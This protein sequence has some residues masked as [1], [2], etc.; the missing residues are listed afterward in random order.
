[1]LRDNRLKATAAEGDP[2]NDPAN[3]GRVYEQT[4]PP[5]TVVPQE[6]EV[7]FK[8]YTAP[9]TPIVSGPGP[10]DA[11]SQDL[12]PNIIPLVNADDSLSIAW[13]RD[14]GKTF[15][16]RY[17]GNDWSQADHIEIPNALA[18]IG[19]F[20]RDAAG[21]EYLLTAIREKAGPFGDANYRPGTVVVLRIPAGARTADLLAD[22]NTEPLC[23]RKIVN[24]LNPG[25]TG[26][27]AVTKLSDG[28]E[29]LGLIFTH[30]HAWDT[31]INDYHQTASPL[32]V[33]TDGQSIYRTAGWNIK[34][35]GGWYHCGDN[36]LVPDGQDMV[37]GWVWESG[38]ALSKMSLINGQGD[39][40]GHRQ[41]F[42]T[43]PEGG[44]FA[45][46]FTG[47]NHYTRLGGIVPAADG[48]LVVFA[49]GD[50]FLWNNG[51]EFRAIDTKV[52]F[53]KAPK[54][55]AEIKDPS[56]G[57]LGWDHGKMSSDFGLRTLAEAPG[58]SLRRARLASVGNG[59]Y[60]VLHE[61]MANNAEY[62][63]AQNK[64]V[65]KFF[66]TNA[67]LIDGTGQVLATQE[68]GDKARIHESN[69]A[70][71]LPA[72]GRAAWVV[73]DAARKRMMLHTLDENLA[74]QS[75]PLAVP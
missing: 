28:R 22:I 59:K 47:H 69:D 49:H 6:T 32:L 31:N 52:N 30:N 60:A 23:D 14:D 67:Q 19:G 53:I 10:I 4:P 15:I 41:V 35:D 36:R 11:D 56:S 54:D 73:G 68:L 75:Y 62:D 17:S 20:T 40:T 27:M 70:F 44:N 29:S 1:M 42:N 65:T 25:F 13:L 18:Q 16:S 26:R 45:S 46:P 50:G 66:G 38:I 33:G 8:V 9:P 74:L 37:V 71:T 12:T 24:P 39:W 58:F 5:N 61:R 57:K 3:V 43:A 21:N 55:F 51:S 48:Y 63:F 2:T 7:S 72:S 64:W 34:F